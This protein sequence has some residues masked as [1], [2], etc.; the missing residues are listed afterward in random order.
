MTEDDDTTGLDVP[1]R[2]LLG[3]IG[4][5]GATSAGAGLGTSA[6]FNDTESFEG[7]SVQ[8]GELDLILEGYTA[9][10]NSDAIDVT[11]GD[12]SSNSVTADG[13]A[14]AAFFTLADVKPGDLA[15]LCLGIT[16]EGNP[17]YLKV[18]GSV[19]SDENSVNEAEAG[20][21][22]NDTL[23]EVEKTGTG[24]LAQN[25]NI[26]AFGP[27]N[28]VDET[29]LD[30]IQEDLTEGSFSST[31]SNGDSN[32]ASG[33]EVLMNQA[34]TESGTDY[35]LSV[36]DG[37]D[38]RCFDSGTYRLYF[39]LSVDTEVGN[40]IQSDSL[41]LDLTVQAVQCRHNDAASPFDDS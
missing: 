11:T 30:S 33:T 23:G 28:S 12:G 5:V 27:N 36:S 34:F 4:A 25:T 6:Y 29:S 24:E 17:A 1:R 39:Q 20:E 21:D 3:A 10:T 7:N 41:D 37:T 14:S 31:T 9:A 35:V 18:D 16:I 19:I 26:Q 8:A 15:I 32:F 38:A 13:T 22:E 2:K 40:V